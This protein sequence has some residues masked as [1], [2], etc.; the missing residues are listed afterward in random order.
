[1]LPA[2]PHRNFDL[3][4]MSYSFSFSSSSLGLGLAALLLLALPACRQSGATIE[5]GERRAPDDSTSLRIACPLTAESLP[6]YYAV[7]SGICDSLGL[8][9]RVKT[10][11]AQFDADT[12]LLG[13]TVDG[14]ITDHYR[15]AYYRSRGRMRNFDEFIPLNGSWSLLAGGRLR[16]RELR[17]LKGRTVGMARYANSDHY[18]TRLRDSLRLKSDDL[19][20]AQVNSF[21]IRH[22]MLENEQIDCAVLPE[23]YASRAVANGNVRL[24]SALPSEMRMSL[25]MNQRA[26]RNKRHNAQSQLLRKAYNLA[27]AA[28]NKGRTPY[29]DSVLV[30]DYQVPAAQLSAIR[31]PHYD[32]T[33]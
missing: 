16:I 20:F 22:L 24:S 23:P 25:Y 33:H 32:A 21:K 11:F 26:L 14:G 10:Y 18:I 28:I 29:L 6:F 30:K 5:S 15:A 12:A 8:P 27:V 13:R 4:Y 19:F 7:R 2:L 1:M 3:F 17:S 31:L 9:L